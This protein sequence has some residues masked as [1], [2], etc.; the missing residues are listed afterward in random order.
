MSASHF[1]LV[2]AVFSD[3]RSTSPGSRRKARIAIVPG[4]CPG[5]GP[6]L[7]TFLT[8]IQHGLQPPFAYRR[9]RSEAVVPFGPGAVTET[10]GFRGRGDAI[11]CGNL[12]SPSLACI[13]TKSRNG[14]LPGVPSPC[15]LMQ[16]ESWCPA[17]RYNRH[18]RL[19][20][21]TEGVTKLARKL[22]HLDLA[23]WT[24]AFSDPRLR[25]DH[26]AQSLGAGLLTPRGPHPF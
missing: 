2:R 7:Q 4:A 18:L 3:P 9:S 6:P 21:P 5:P 26:A 16:P 23:M 14:R 17:V 22:V 13:P 1:P 8:A 20:M 24:Y 19:P 11:D 10:F 15:T 25:Q 12:V